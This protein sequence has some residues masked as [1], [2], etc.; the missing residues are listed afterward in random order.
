MK[1]KG[2]ATLL[3]VCKGKISEGLNFHDELG[4]LVIMIGIPFPSLNHPKVKLKKQFMN[5]EDFKSGDKWYKQEGMRAVNQ[6]IGRVIR[7][8]KDY[9]AILLLD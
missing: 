1:E 8:S 7:H 3:A 9:G 5:E 4:R 6:A 2:G